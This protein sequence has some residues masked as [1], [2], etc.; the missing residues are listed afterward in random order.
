MSDPRSHPFYFLE[1]IM[2]QSQFQA[3]VADQAAADA[4]VKNTEN[5]AGVRFVNVNADTGVIVVTH[6]DDFDADAFKTA[7]GI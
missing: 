4:I 5:V 7:A 3:T 2:P 1:F 6:G